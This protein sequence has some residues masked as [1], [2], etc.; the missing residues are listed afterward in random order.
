MSFHAGQVVGDYTI[1]SV[2]GGGA[3]GLVYKIEH[4]ITKR[5][6]A[7]K[8]LAN[9][10]T[11]WEQA[12]RFM[13]EI[14]LQARLSHPNIAAV[15]NAF[16][17]DNELLLVM[18]LVS[19]Q[20][21][22]RKVAH[23]PVPLE[24]GLFYVSQVLAALAY[25]HTQGVVH[26]DVSPA[27][28]IVTPG[29]VIKLTDFGLA[30]A[31]GDVR[32]TNTGAFAGSLHYISPEQVRG[33]ADPDPRSDIYST[34][35]VLYEIATG[36][37]VFPLDSAFALM[38]AQTSETP[39][40]PREIN[41]C[42]PQSLNDAILK[43]LAKDPADRFQTADEFR[44]ALAAVI[45]EP[46]PRATI[47]RW[48]LVAYAVIGLSAAAVVSELAYLKVGL[49]QPAAMQKTTAAPL[50]TPHI[51]LPP[52]PPLVAPSTATQEQPDPV[53]PVPVPHR[54]P[55]PAVGPQP[56][57]VILGLGDGSSNPPASTPATKAADT[58]PPAPPYNPDATG[59]KENV[60]AAADPTP[61][62]APETP[63][64][65]KTQ[66]EPSKTTKPHGGFRR[67]LGKIFGS[68]PDK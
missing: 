40:A 2:V 34:G 13:R 60:P 39:D 19:G 53:A 29:G 7:M 31:P 64:E 23:E 52:A 67:A 35:A 49:S 11:S 30:R 9:P 20:S 4:N 54:K 17:L 58:P 28:I 44:E 25:S 26:R 38:Q 24:T 48:Q 42:I 66:A 46:A 45:I 15:H 51:V 3:T 43:A 50:I 21:L 32:V 18:E 33:T 1:V 6:E 56:E 55:K 41:P 16:W 59:V 37:K 65:T 5:I 36:R 68:H 10:I 57:P 22:E 8:T 14:Q 27:N 62:A 12:Q 63:A 47:P 61:K